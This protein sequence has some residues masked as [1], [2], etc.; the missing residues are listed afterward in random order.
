MGSDRET[1]VADG[2]AQYVLVTGEAGAARLRLLHAVY[3][4]STETLLAELGLARGMSVADI[5][6]GTGT[7]SRWLAGAVGSSGRVEGVD[8]S[9]AQLEVARRDAQR[10]GL[11]QLRFECADAYD[12]RLPRQSFDIVYCRFLLCHL[13]QPGRAL[14]EMRA[15]LKPNGALVCD[16]VDVAS[17]FADPPSPAVE[18]MRDLM[19]AVGASR[20]VDFRL[21]IRLHRLF[22]SVGLADPRVRLDQPVYATGEEKRIWEYT[23]LEAAPAMI[24]A[25]LLT[26][27]ELDRLSRELAAVA[28]DETVMV[29]QARKVQVWARAPGS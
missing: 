17:I 15:L 18:R 16:D 2:S 24:Q 13:E 27:A 22:R 28:H 9:L 20:G 21:G 19:L 3:G 6:C 12:T 11:T 26:P 7:V 1:P 4:R 5:G 25:G 23:F 29:A 10:Q 14:A 8:V